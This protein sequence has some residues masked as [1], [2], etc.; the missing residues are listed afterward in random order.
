MK[1]VLVFPADSGFFSIRRFLFGIDVPDE[2]M[3]W[4]INPSVHWI[5]EGVP[6]FSEGWCKSAILDVLDA[7]EGHTRSSCMDESAI[8]HSG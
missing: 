1:Q 8:C 3:R 5:E 2:P 6:K 4:I 7:E